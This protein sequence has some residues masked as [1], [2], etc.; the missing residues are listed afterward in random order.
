MGIL[1]KQEITQNYLKTL[2]EY[3]QKTGNLIWLKNKRQKT[4]GKIA[5]SLGSKGHVEIKIDGIKYQAH[6]LV[7][8]YLNGNFPTNQIDHINRI[9]SDNRIEN[10]RE[11]TNSENKQNIDKPRGYSN[12]YMGVYFHKKRKKWRSKITKEGVQY[13]LGFF[14]T[15]ELAK[16]AYLDAKKEL[17]PFYTI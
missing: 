13:E 3:D 7:W 8:L 15:P 11:V 10:L 12:P 9:K 17:H 2:F 5:G 1:C 4:K 16:K 6:R 14:D